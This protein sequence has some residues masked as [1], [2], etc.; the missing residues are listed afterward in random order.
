MDREEF[1]RTGDVGAVYYE[2]L[3]L[4]SGE[5][6]IYILPIGVIYAIAARQDNGHFEFTMDDD[7]VIDAG[8]EEWFVW[9][10]SSAINK[11]VRAFKFVWDSDTATGSITVK[12]EKV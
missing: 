12:T 11:G 2:N 5:S 9:N 4:T 7:D 8:N 3:E 10:G 1:V 6:D